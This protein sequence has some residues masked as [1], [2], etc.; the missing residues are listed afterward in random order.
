MSSTKDELT[1]KESTPQ[2]TSLKIYLDKTSGFMV[3]LSASCASNGVGVFFLATAGT[4]EAVP[5][6][7]WYIDQSDNSG[8]QVADVRIVVDGG[9]VHTAQAWPQKDGHT[10]YTNNLGL[11]FY[12]PNIV[13]RSMQDQE[14]NANTGILPLDGLLAPYVKQA[15]KANAQSWAD[16][17]AGP[18]TTLLNAKSV[19]IELPITNE[20]IKPIIDLNPQDK[21]LHQFVSDCYA[22]FTSGRR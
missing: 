8:E 10:L 11:L 2:P 16:N 19:R 21:V 17:S 14:D 7:A 13:S 6:Y 9:A 15:A 1:G 5:Q 3:S 4:N 12:E 20:A 18:M 22:K